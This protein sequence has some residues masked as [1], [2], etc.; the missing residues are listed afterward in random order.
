M[1]SH[2][3]NGLNFP[4]HQIPK[5][6]KGVNSFEHLEHCIGRLVSLDLDIGSCSIVSF[7]FILFPSTYYYYL[8]GSFRWLLTGCRE[9]GHKCNPL[10][11]ANVSSRAP[12]GLDL[13]V[14]DNGITF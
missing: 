3:I 8:V 2:K 10:L 6:K 11:L 7:I 4:F 14:L 13:D 12:L 5:Q 1:F 9:Q